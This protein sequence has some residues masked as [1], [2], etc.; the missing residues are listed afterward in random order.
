MD[1]YLATLET[2]SVGEKAR[3]DKPR[4]R[5]FI[6]NDRKKSVQL[7]IAN[8][9]WF[10]EKSTDLEEVQA[11]IALLARTYFRI[12]M[13]GLMTDREMQDCI[14]ACRFYH[15]VWSTILDEELRPIMPQCH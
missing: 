7:K 3:W 9:Q 2:K 6:R 14:A 11:K 13:G 1:E 10:V 4:T 5:W 12:K 15:G 8:M